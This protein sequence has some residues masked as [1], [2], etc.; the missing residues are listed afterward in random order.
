MTKTKNALSCSMSLQN[1]I[2]QDITHSIKSKDSSSLMVLRMLKAAISNAC[3]Q[4]GNINSELTDDK[5]LSLIRKQISQR[6]DS[7]IQFEKAGRN[8]LVE[9][10][11][12]EIS[13]LEKYLPAKL[14]VE[15]IQI[16]VE[17][18]ISELGATSKKDLGKVI[19]NVTEKTQGAAD[20]KTIASVASKML[21]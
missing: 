1:Q 4:N 14:S 16:L 18:A 6:Q 19:K 15:E 11:K 5:I 17:T 7:V 21:N 9:N 20:G 8:E 3:V 2:N 12:N 13:I 10:E